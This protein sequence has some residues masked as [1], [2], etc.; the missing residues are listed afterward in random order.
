M[1]KRYFFTGLALLLPAVITI[2]LA[3]FFVN[4]LTKPFQQGVVAVL[5]ELGLIKPF[6]FLSAEQVL[7]IIS[8]ILILI[9][10]VAITIIAG[11]LAQIVFARYLIRIAD[12]IIHKI[13]IVNKIYKAAQDVVHTLFKSEKQAFTQV[14]L[15]PFPHEKSYGIGLITSECV[16]EEA[17]SEHGNLISVFVPATPNPTMGFMLM[18]KRKQ[19]IFVDMTVEEALQAIISCGVMISTINKSTPKS[20]KA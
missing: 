13:P 2:I 14:V 15:V 20:I 18:L 4:L 7:N 3:V 10:L 6:L 12:I 11:I 8:K 17:D 5:S 16:P 1:I 9:T 19:V